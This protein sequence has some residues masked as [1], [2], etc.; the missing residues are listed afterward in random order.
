MWTREWPNDGVSLLPCI[1]LLQFRL[2]EKKLSEISLSEED[3]HT[4]L[5]IFSTSSASDLSGGPM[6]M[7][8]QRVEINNRMRNGGD[9]KHEAPTCKEEGTRHSCVQNFSEA[10]R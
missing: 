1:F 2:P 6:W 8:E 10:N 9:R 4:M 7:R 5:A 3:Q